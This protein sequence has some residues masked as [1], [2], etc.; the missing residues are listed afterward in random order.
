MLLNL[1]IDFCEESKEGDI[2]FESKFRVTI[3][4]ILAEVNWN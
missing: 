3:Q 4:Y 1:W 2:N